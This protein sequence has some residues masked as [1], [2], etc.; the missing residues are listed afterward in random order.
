MLTAGFSCSGE[1]TSNNMSAFGRFYYMRPDKWRVDVLGS[2]FAPKIVIIRNK[3][4][5]VY[6]EAM[7]DSVSG[8]AGESSGTWRIFSTAVR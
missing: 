1:F 6:P 7:K 3:S 2:F 5:M 8:I 4:L